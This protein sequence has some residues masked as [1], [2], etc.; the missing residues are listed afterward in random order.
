MT[1]SSS[2]LTYLV[3]TFVLVVTPGASTAVVIRSTLV[4]GRLGGVA[5]AAGAAAGNTSYAVASGFGLT[6]LFMRWP[7]APRTISILGA[8]YFV[9]LGGQ[10]LL[11]AVRAGDGGGTTAG[12]CASDDITPRQ[13]F[14]QG[15]GV[16]L[17]NP[18]I[19]TF[20]LSIVPTFVPLGAPWWFF[21]LLAA[22]HVGMA[23]VC[24][25]AWAVA[26][27][28][29]RHFFG[30]RAFHRTIEVAAG[31]AMLLLA[32]RVLATIRWSG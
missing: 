3:V 17:L 21:S 6:V 19:A 8:L 7:A 9:W 28:R 10:N 4:G 12:S 23:F 15:L 11:H 18:A 27:D 26:F 2:V 13:S 32:W 20:Y 16:N 29:L 14:R 1:A 25:S 31:L 5:A 30:R 24:H 22:S